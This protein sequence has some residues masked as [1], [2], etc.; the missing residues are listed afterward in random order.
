MS[1]MAPSLP[2]LVPRMGRVGEQEVGWASFCDAV[3]SH[4]QLGLPLSMAVSGKSG[5]Y[6]SAG[7]PQSKHSKKEEVKTANS[8]KDK[9]EAT[10]PFYELVSEVTHHYFCFILV[11]RSSSLCLANTQETGN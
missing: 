3:F 11:I 4:G 2:C 9:T 7:F 10:V 8:L 1:K 6:T 5:F